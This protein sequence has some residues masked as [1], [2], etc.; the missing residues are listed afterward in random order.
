MTPAQMVRAMADAGATAE[1]IAIALEALE[2]ASAPDEQAERRRAA[3]RERKRAK[4]A[5]SADCPQM[6]AECPQTRPQTRA[7]TPP[8]PLVP[9]PNTPTP[10]NTPPYNPPQTPVAMSAGAT[11]PKPEPTAKARA[12]QL[13]S[14]F[15]AFWKAYPHKVSRKQAAVAFG[16]AALKHGAPTIM[17]GLE[18]ALAKDRRFTDP[19][20]RD[21]RCV[22]PHAA[23][24]LNAE[25]FL[26]EHSPRPEPGLFQGPHGPARGN[27]MAGGPV[28]RP[29]NGRPRGLVE[30]AMQYLEAA[31]ELRPTG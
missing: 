3:D 31:S 22:T 28:S 15:E 20:A 30:A 23:T 18:R 14:D 25:G 9:P 7:D 1:V 26:D 17:G 11:P 6:S 4:R 24:W 10:P 21:G 13:A 2:A 8:P 29:N 5:I 19:I 27:G 12:D 16:R